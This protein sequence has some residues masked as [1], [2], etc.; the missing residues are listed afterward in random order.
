MRSC[1]S[2]LPTNQ[3]YIASARSAPTRLPPQSSLSNSTRVKF[4]VQRSGPSSPKHARG[5]HESARSSQAEILRPR[6]GEGSSECAAISSGRGGNR[7]RY[8]SAAMCTSRLQAKP[9]VEPLV[10]RGV[11]PLQPAA[12]LCGGGEGLEGQSGVAIPIPD[13]RLGPRN[14]PRAARA[15][16]EGPGRVL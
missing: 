1:L 7:V 13:T 9:R 15:R 11:V 4:L 10:V 6:G 2:S 8:S 14:A 12:R 3:S 16:P 5:M